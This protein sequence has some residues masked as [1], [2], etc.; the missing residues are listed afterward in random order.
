MFNEWHCREIEFFPVWSP[1]QYHQGMA[2]WRGIWI[3]KDRNV[4]IPW[5]SKPMERHLA[6][7]AKGGLFGTTIFVNALVCSSDSYICEFCLFWYNCVLQWNHYVMGGPVCL[8][9]P[10]AFQV[11]MQLIKL[12]C[13]RFH[14]EHSFPAP[15]PPWAFNALGTCPLVCWVHSTIIKSLA[16]R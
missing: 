13:T 1:I 2:E 9:P 11:R 6:Y 16:H 10:R 12:T 7:D 15:K 5:R 8:C 3:S 14:S 4:S